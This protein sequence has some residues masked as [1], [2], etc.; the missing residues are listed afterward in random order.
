MKRTMMRRRGVAGLAAL[1]LMGLGA[2][3]ALRATGTGR[4]PP[5][6]D[7]SYTI[8]W[9]SQTSEFRDSVRVAL[10]DSAALRAFLSQHGYEEVPEKWRTDFERHIVLVAGLGARQTAGY[11]ICVDS[12]RARP[13]GATAYV[14][15]IESGGGQQWVT[16]PVHAVRTRVR[17][18]PLV[19]EETIL[20][21]GMCEPSLE[22][23]P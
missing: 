19:F 20:D 14:T 9:R 10:R 18:A 6:A 17:D 1:L 16:A 5:Q 12:V 13:P 3:D 4:R 21:E 23:E 2:C 22:V 7:S 11:A 15:R 8:L